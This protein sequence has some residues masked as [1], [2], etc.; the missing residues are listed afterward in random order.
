[1]RDTAKSNIMH[2]AWRLAKTYWT[3]EE[4]W[5]AWGLLVA[6][7]ALNLGNV[8]ISVRINDWNRSFYSALQAFDSGGLFRQLGIFCVLVTF[9]ISMSAYALYLNQMLQ[10]RW[11]RWLTRRSSPWF[12]FFSSSGGSPDLWRSRSASGEQHTYL[13]IS[14]GQRCSTPGSVLGSL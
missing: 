10:I 13:A 14:S 6:V 12:R 5:A 2:D 9:A 7:V 8:Y 11:R 4:K 3:S 1:M